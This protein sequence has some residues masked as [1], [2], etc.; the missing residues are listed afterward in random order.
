MSAP[1]KDPDLVVAT[2]AL[3]KFNNGTGRLTAAEEDFLVSLLCAFICRR[4]ST[5]PATT[6][7]VQQST[8]LRDHSLRTLWRF[9]RPRHRSDRAAAQALVELQHQLVRQPGLT[10]DPES[11]ESVATFYLGS[12]LS[13]PGG[14]P[15]EERQL[16]KIA[17][18]R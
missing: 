10:V 13:W 18:G 8:A 17:K 3:E 4:L 14:K 7:Q 11:E 15:L 6:L 1:V 16:R 2:A 9:V 12:A 5:G